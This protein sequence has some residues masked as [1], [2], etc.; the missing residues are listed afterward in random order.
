MEDAVT[1]ACWQ[2]IPPKIIHV[3]VLMELIFLLMA[4][5][6]LERKPHGSQPLQLP[7]LQVNQQQPPPKVLKPHRKQLQQDLIMLC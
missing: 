3:D 1:S 4:H 5:H 7:L 2:L 6:A